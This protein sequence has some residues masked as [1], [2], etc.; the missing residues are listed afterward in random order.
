MTPQHVPR[1]PHQPDNKPIKPK[2][3]RDFIIQAYRELMR[4]VGQEAADRGE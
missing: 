4:H 2:F 1:M 3:A